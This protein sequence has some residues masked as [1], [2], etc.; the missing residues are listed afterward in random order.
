MGPSSNRQ[1]V[2]LYSLGYT[3]VNLLKKIIMSIKFRDRP[4]GYKM[5][6]YEMDNL[7]RQ[8]LSDDV[9]F[10]KLHHLYHHT[11]MNADKQIVIP[12]NIE[13]SRSEDRVKFIRPIFSDHYVS[14][15]KSSIYLDIGCGDMSITS[16]I[17]TMLHAENNIY[18]VDIVEPKTVPDGIVF[19]RLQDTSADDDF[20]LPF[21]NNTF[22]VAS[23]MMSLHHIK[24]I[25]GC[26]DEIKRVMAPGGYFLIREHDCTSYELSVVIDLMHACY[27]M[28]FAEP[29]EMEDFRKHFSR[30]ETR[31]SITERISS[32][33]FKHIFSTEPIGMWRHYYSL[34]QCVKPFDVHPNDINQ[35]VVTISNNLSLDT[36]DIVKILLSSSYHNDVVMKETLQSLLHS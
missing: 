4:V 15:Y 8:G 22:T 14:N 7:V 11:L 6:I 29:T 23:A 21:T 10:E 19:N 17:G 33:H 18:G 28:I 35:C 9:I 3:Y 20:V 25:D 12:D 24:N 30:Y 36:T 34:F 13:F 26:L 32:H 27:A 31:Q 5:F 16:A 1:L 2:E